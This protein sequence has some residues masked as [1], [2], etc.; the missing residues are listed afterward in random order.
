VALPP[1][2]HRRSEGEGEGGRL[3]RPLRRGAVR[4]VRRGARVLFNSLLSS[5]TLRADGA[6]RRARALRPRS[7]RRRPRVPLARAR[8]ERGSWAGDPCT[9]RLFQGALRRPIPAWLSQ[10]VQLVAMHSPQC[11]WQIEV[12]DLALWKFADDFESSTWLH[13]SASCRS[14]CSG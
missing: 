12:V 13:Q 5:T 10:V 11:R 6:C 1:Q 3:T 2:S 7:A 9:V 4:V 14:L 8:G